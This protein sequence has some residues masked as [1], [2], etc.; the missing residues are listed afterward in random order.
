MINLN[1]TSSFNPLDRVSPNGVTSTSSG[2]GVGESRSVL[3]IA[4]GIRGLPPGKLPVLNGLTKAF[5]GSSVFGGTGEPGN[6]R[7]VDST[8]SGAQSVSRDYRGAFT[9]PAGI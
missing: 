8:G 3:A 4:A 2:T 5:N 6:T 9:M 1:R 7:L